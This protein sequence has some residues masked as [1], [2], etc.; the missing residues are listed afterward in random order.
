[1]FLENLV[2]LELRRRGYEL[3]YW[4]SNERAAEVDFV[5]RKGG[6]NPIAV[7]VSLTMR[8]ESTLQRELRGLELISKE[9]GLR[10]CL[11]IT[12]EDISRTFQHQGLEIRCLP[13]GDWAV[14]P[15][16]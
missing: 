13:F 10:D 6:Q 3:H 11:L 5:A 12:K 2:Y 9:L 1:M 4:I 14:D 15:S 16:G 7:Q 8:D